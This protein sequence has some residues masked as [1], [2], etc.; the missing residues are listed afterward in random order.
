MGNL[1]NCINDS[2]LKTNLMKEKTTQIFLGGAIALPIGF[3]LGSI[4]YIAYGDDT[5]LYMDIFSI[6]TGMSLYWVGKILAGKL[7]K[8]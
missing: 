3:L 5:S 7:L 4:S 6:V 2:K 8:K 1:N